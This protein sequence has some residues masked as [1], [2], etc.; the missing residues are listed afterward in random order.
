[1]ETVKAP[2]D[3]VIREAGALLGQG[4]KSLGKGKT[5]ISSFQAVDG[6]NLQFNEVHL[7]DFP[8]KAFQETVMCPATF[9]DNLMVRYLSELNGDFW[10]R[11]QAGF[12]IHF[13]S[14][15]ASATTCV[16]AVH[17]IGAS[18]YTVL[19]KIQMVY[20]HRTEMIPQG[21]NMSLYDGFHSKDGRYVWIYWRYRDCC[22]TVSG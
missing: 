5:S 12:L 3:Y 16:R 11:K 20:P 6:A 9:G 4:L 19:D 1:M 18:S 7:Y 13:S 15:V 14:L 21:T 2:G 8:L 10:R 17:A 22:R